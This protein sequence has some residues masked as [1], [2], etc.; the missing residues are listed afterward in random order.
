MCEFN[1]VCMHQQIELNEH[2]SSV[3]INLVFNYKVWSVTVNKID[4]AGYTVYDKY[5][6]WLLS[7]ETSY[8]TVLS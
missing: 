4:C 8:K 5:E 2:F 3:G 6:V 1:V 7:N